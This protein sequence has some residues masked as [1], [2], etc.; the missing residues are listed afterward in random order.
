MRIV[1]L[2]DEDARAHRG[3][4]VTTIRAMSVDFAAVADRRKRGLRAEDQFGN[5]ER[6][7]GT[8]Y[9]TKPDGSDGLG[10]RI[11]LG[12]EGEAHV[13]DESNAEVAQSVVLF[14][15][16]HGTDVEVV[17]DVREVHAGNGI[18]GGK[19]ESSWRYNGR[20]CRLEGLNVEG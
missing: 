11:R 9:R 14:E 13:D 6:E 7:E 4:A 8:V 3:S 1:A 15:V 12:R 18:T 16:G 5:R 2:R 20:S 10:V 19:V 17:G